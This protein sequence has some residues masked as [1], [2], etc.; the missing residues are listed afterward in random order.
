M[1]P[2]AICGLQ[3]GQNHCFRTRTC[4]EVVLFV[5]IK[6]LRPPLPRPGMRRQYS[7]ISAFFDLVNKSFFF[8]N[9]IQKCRW[10]SFVCEAVQQLYR[11][12]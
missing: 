1:W 2:G 12:N 4:I 10:G 6:K 9:R 5:L 3:R 8:K 7:T 11:A